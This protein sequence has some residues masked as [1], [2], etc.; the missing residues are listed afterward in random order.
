MYA[1]CDARLWFFV[2][3][4][5]IASTNQIWHWCAYRIRSHSAWRS[6]TKYIEGSEFLNRSLRNYSVYDDDDD[7]NDDN[8]YYYSNVHFYCVATT[9]VRPIIYIFS[10][11]IFHTVVLDNQFVYVPSN[12]TILSPDYSAVLY[13]FNRT[14]CFGRLATIVRSNKSYRPYTI[15]RLSQNYVT[16][17]HVLSII[18]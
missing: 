5:S 11:S 13:K 12:T 2:S 15:P 1:Q 4:F 14:T 8:N 17:Y 9:A 10:F 6:A 16:F 7:D 3:K 18:I